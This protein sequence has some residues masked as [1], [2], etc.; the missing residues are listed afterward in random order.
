MPET[1]ASK[2]ALDVKR[3]LRIGRRAEIAAA[4]AAAEV[5]TVPIHSSAG[6]SH[7]LPHTSCGMNNM[8]P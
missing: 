5:A 8:L 1:L 4:E 3:A 7:L 6:C 2:L